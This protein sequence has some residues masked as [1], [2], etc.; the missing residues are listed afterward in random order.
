MAERIGTHSAHDLRPRL[1]LI[2]IPNSN[3]VSA[4]VAGHNGYLTIRD[5]LAL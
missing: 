4:I 2:V 5:T 1:S 3:C